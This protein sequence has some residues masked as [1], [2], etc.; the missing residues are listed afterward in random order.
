MY[1]WGNN[2]KGQV[3]N[4]QSSNSPVTRPTLIAPPG[5]AVESA[6]MK[7]R[8]EYAKK[9]SAATCSAVS[10][11]DWQVVTGV[12]K[13]AYSVSGPADGTSIN[14]NSTD[15]ELPSGAIASRPQSLVRKSGVAGTFTNA[16]KISAGEVGVW[17]LALVDKGLD[18]NE[19]YASA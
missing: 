18:R 12:S 3:G 9:G 1:C 10:S 5:G 14:S 16:Q 8:V 2:N 19:N 15:P 17:D 11:S 4:G 6:S 7:L 13:L